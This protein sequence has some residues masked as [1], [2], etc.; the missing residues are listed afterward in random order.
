MKLIMGEPESAELMDSQ[1]QWQ[2]TTLES[3]AKDHPGQTWNRQRSQSFGAEQG[4][5]P[6]SAAKTAAHERN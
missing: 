2:L 1:V 6:L 5:L 4:L 3:N